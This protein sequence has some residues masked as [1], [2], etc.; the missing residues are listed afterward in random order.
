ME[1]PPEPPQPPQAQ[2][3]PLPAWVMLNPGGLDLADPN[4]QPLLDPEDVD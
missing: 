2:A 3:V 4:Q 1:E